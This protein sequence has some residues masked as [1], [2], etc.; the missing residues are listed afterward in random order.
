MIITVGRQIGSGGHD[1]AKKLAEQIGYKFYDMEI[2]SIAAQESGFDRKFFEKQD[3]KRGFFRSIFG[4]AVPTGAMVNYSGT[5]TNKFSQESL[6]LFQA[7]A[8]KNAAS[9]GNCIFVGRCADYILREF[10]NLINLFVTADYDERVGR[11]MTRN[12]M[13]REQA[14]KLIRDKE[15]ARSSF[16]NYYTGKKWGDSS[17]Y[18][19][20]LNSSRL[21]IEGSVKLIKSLISEIL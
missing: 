2:L 15:D 19:F 10:P 20:C 7:E 1:I 11:V 6:F 12:A 5:Y 4:G 21:G 9:E 14:E 17:S 8:I 3:E 13:T 16:Y 18:D